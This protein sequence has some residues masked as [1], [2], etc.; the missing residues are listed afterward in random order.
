MNPFFLAGGLLSI[1]LSV[2]HAFW[3][4]RYIAPE[5]K[6]SNMSEVPKVGFYISYHQI[7]LTLLISGLAL[8]IISIFNSITGIDNLALFISIIIIGNF[9]VFIIISIVK[10]RK[11]LGQSIPQMFFFTLMIALIILGIIF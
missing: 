2:A 4:E 6:T 10:Y 1:I 5:L 3:G 7:T 9:L 8:V 11:L